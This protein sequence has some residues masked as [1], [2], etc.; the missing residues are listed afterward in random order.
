[1]KNYKDVPIPV[2]KK[3]IDNIKTYRKFELDLDKIES[4][5]DCKKILKFLCDRSLPPLGDGLVY[6]GFDEVEK[7]FK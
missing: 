6:N 7:Y 3:K 4:I 2:P 1:M 5:N